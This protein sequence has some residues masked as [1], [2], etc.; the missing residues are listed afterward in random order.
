MVVVP[1]ATASPYGNEAAG[2]APE[3]G[4][5]KRV[6]RTGSPFCTTSGTSRLPS[7]TSTVMESKTRV[8][9]ARR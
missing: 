9:Q 5:S 7:G 6:S 3:A 2:R 8:Q 1:T 4:F